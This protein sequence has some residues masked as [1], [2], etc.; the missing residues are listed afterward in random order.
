MS[1]RAKSQNR[2]VEPRLFDSSNPTKM[3][4]KFL[5]NYSRS[6]EDKNINGLDYCTIWF[7]S[8]LICVSDGRWGILNR[9]SGLK[10]SFYLLMLR[11]K[12]PNLLLAAIHSMQ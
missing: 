4:R 10:Y 12:P 3:M 5:D 6:H 11:W 7:R 9:D 8:N 2:I 1:M